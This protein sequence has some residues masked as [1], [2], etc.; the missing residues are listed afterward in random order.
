MAIQNIIIVTTKSS[1]IYTANTAS[2]IVANIHG[3]TKTI[4]L[5]GMGISMYIKQSYVL[6]I[7][8]QL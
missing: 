6:A 7:H 8:V 2:Y 5:Q 1:Y 4:Y 3:A